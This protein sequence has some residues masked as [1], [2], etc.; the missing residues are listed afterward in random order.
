M[1]MGEVLDPGTAKFAPVLQPLNILRCHPAPCSDKTAAHSELSAQHRTL[2]EDSRSLAAENEQLRASL[3]AAEQRAQQAETLGA[4]LQAE[5]KAA[6]ELQAALQEDAAGLKAELHQASNCTLWLQHVSGPCKAAVLQ[7]LSWQETRAA[8]WQKVCTT[9]C[10]IKNCPCPPG[11]CVG[12][13]AG[14]PPAGSAG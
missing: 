3:A 2:Q 10:V 7:R 12:A 13:G 9:T 6:K 8:A 11:S 5:C 14:S 1:W 4:G